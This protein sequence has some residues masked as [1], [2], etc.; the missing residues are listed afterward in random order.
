MTNIEQLNEN[1]F[2]ETISK[3]THLVDFWA[4]WCGPC[5]AMA[6]ILEQFDSQNDFDASVKKVDV[7]ENQNIAAKYNISS[8]PTM[9]LFED[10]K[11]IKRVVGAMPLEALNQKLK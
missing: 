7:D 11:E 5:K 8:I 9:I 10:G 6:P 3:G 4:T 1:N 2:K